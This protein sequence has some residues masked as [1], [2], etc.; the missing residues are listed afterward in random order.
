MLVPLFN[1]KIQFIRKNLNLYLNNL[2]IFV[3]NMGINIVGKI[4]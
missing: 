1:L 3:A 4:I 2:K